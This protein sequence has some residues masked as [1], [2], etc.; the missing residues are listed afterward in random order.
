MSNILIGIIA[1]LF[2][3]LIEIVVCFVA[4][5][6]VNKVTNKTKLDCRNTCISSIRTLHVVA[7]IGVIYF[8][9][10]VALV[11][12][13]AFNSLLIGPIILLI[14]GS[15]VFVTN[16]IIIPVFESKHIQLVEKY[17]GKDSKY[18][19]FLIEEQQKRQ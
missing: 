6:L 11:I 17:Y 18:A 1:I 8:V 9:P 16:K 19:K 3:Y 5:R 4:I 7:L 10:L 15:T 13:L 14:L 12:C 2:V